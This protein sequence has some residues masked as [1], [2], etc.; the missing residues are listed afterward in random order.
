MVSR[1]AANVGA[2]KRGDVG[3]R[4]HTSEKSVIENSRSFPAVS[5]SD[6]SSHSNVSESAPIISTGRAMNNS[7]SHQPVTH[8]K[9]QTVPQAGEFF[10]AT[11]SIAATQQSEASSQQ[12]AEESLETPLL[13][14]QGTTSKAVVQ[15]DLTYLPEISRKTECF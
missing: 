8:Q 5:K 15:P 2:I 14:D 7:T 9:V 3:V 11:Q 4:R 10:K 13:K 12:A 1:P 6:Q